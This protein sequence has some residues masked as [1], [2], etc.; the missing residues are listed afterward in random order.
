MYVSGKLYG[1]AVT[2]QLVIKSWCFSS[3]VREWDGKKMNCFPVYRCVGHNCKVRVSIEAVL[4]W[5]QTVD[6][7][8]KCTI[9]ERWLKS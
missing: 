6:P 2:R 1:P 5:L 9:F 3:A 8:G 7:C 4:A